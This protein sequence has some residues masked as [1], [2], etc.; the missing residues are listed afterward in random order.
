MACGHI[1]LTPKSA[2]R[3]SPGFNFISSNK[4]IITLSNSHSL[5]R[6]MNAL[7][8]LERTCSARWY[9]PC[10]RKILACTFSDQRTPLV[11]LVVFLCRWLINIRLD[12]FS[13][14][15][16]RLK[17][18]YGAE[19]TIRYDRARWLEGTRIMNF[20]DLNFNVSLHWR[21]GGN[22]GN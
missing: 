2:L 17:C 14:E 13:V 3:V 22:S 19:N 20:I 18:S 10:L 21:Q 1:D 9:F 7:K 6:M 8:D 12:S 16:R 15:S 4:F 11:T 5:H